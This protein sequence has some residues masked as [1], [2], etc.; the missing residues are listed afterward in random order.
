MIDNL[1]NIAIAFI[2]SKQVGKCLMFSTFRQFISHPFNNQS[3]LY[4]KSRCAALSLTRVEEISVIK[5]EFNET[6]L[7]FLIEEKK[8]S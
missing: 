6:K 1:P 3:W 5:N 2:K 4:I 8:N 7:D